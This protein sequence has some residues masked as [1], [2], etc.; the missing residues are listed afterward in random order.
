M[1]EAGS[2]SN[3]VY[4]ACNNSTAAELAVPCT[5]EQVEEAPGQCRHRRHI[6]PGKCP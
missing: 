5:L 6:V 1:Y 4:R 2:Q 3:C